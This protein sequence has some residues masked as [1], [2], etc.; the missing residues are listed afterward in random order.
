M[1]PKL[2]VVI[3][4][5]NRSELISETIPTL[6]NQDVPQD[7][8]NVIIVNNNSDDDTSKL[9]DGFLKQFVNVAIIDEKNQGL[10]YSKNA[11]MNATKTKW[12]VYLDDDAKVPTDFIS[13]ALNIIEKSDYI[14]F[15]GVYLPWYKYGKPKWYLDTYASNKD[16]LLKLGTLEEDF[17]AGGIMAIRK[18][19]LLQ[20]GGFATNI[21]MSG[22]SI[23]YGE[24]TQLQIQLRYKGYN[25]GYDPHWII[26]HLVGKYKLS[27][28]WF[29]KSGFASGR[30]SWIIY[31]EKPSMKKMLQYLIR[32]LKLLVINIYK[33]TPK[34]INKNY[35]F[36]NWIIDVLRPSTLKLGQIIGGIKLIIK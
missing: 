16:K 21:G 11:G 27:P 22:T 12:I 8:Y 34:L 28:S 17:I 10:S 32:S 31:H 24:E 19:I 26:H 20:Q 33:K 2:T 35:Y 36:Q 5:Y 4:T 15:G 9:L 29:L 3:C 30:D 13:K 1:Q 6:F 14:C 18:D 23:A 25:I 7:S